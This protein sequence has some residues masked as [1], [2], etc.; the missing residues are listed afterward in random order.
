MTIAGIKS[1]HLVE[2]IAKEM[3]LLTLELQV[4]LN[5]EQGGV[6]VTTRLYEDVDDLESMLGAPWFGQVH[7][8]RYLA[9][10]GSAGLD[11]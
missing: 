3:E 10:G 11:V 7:Q 9:C 8:G 4:V 1:C 6:Y 5:S 2:E